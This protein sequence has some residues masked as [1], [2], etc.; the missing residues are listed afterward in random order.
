MKLNFKQNRT[1]QNGL[2]QMANTLNEWEIPLTL[3]KIKQSIVEGDKNETTEKISFQ[4]V[5]QPLRQDQ[6]QSKPENYR[7]WSWY[8]IH[9]KAGSLNLMTG[10]KIIFENKRYKIMGLKDYSLYG[11]IEYEAILD[12][13]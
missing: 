3:E 2:P 1:L 7:S 8:W 10:D 6:L 13:E 12:Y 9:C 5:F 4:G 11:Y